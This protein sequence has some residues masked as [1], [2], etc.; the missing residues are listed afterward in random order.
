MAP[1]VDHQRAAKAAAFK[2]RSLSLPSSTLTT[3]ALRQQQRPLKERSDRWQQQPTKA[4]MKEK[5][6]RSQTTEGELKALR[7]FR[8]IEKI[9]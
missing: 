3:P 1:L 5:L 6:K 2:A 8:K 9:M 4:D 7:T